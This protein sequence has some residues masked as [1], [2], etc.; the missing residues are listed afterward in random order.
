M[1]GILR[2]YAKWLIDYGKEI[3]KGDTTIF[4]KVQAFSKEKI[5]NDY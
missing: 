4:P 2:T 3:L 1:E 5:K